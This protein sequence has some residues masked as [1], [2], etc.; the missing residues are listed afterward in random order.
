MMRKWLSIFLV[1][2]LLLMLCITGCS[3]DSAVDG[4]SSSLPENDSSQSTDT[5]ADKS[6]QGID[7]SEQITFTYLYPLGSGFQVVDSMNDN[8]I[9]K[10]VCELKNVEIE[11]IHPPQGQENEQFN[12]IIASGE[13]PDVITHGWGIPQKFP[14]GAS[15]AIDDNVYIPLN[16]L[17]DN[18]AP[19]FL[20]IIESYENVRKDFTTDN[21][22]IWGMGMVD[23]TVQPQWTGPTIRKDMFDKLN[24]EVPETI[25]EWYSALKSFVDNKAQFPDMEAPLILDAN[26]MGGF[27]TFIG[28]YDVTNDFI[29]YNGAVKYGP[30]EE[31]FKQYLLEMN[32]WYNEGLI[33][34]DFAAGLD[35]GAYI[36]TDKCAALATGGFWEYDG[37]KITSGDEN[38]KV[39]GAPF[40][41]TIKGEKVQISYMARR[42]HLGYHTAI[43]TT[44]ENPDRVV[45]FLDWFYSDEGSLLAN[46]GVENEDWKWENDNQ[47]VYTDK[48]AKNEEGVAIPIIYFKYLYSHG[49]F[50]R[51][52][53][54]ECP[55]YGIE[56]N[57]CMWTWLDSSE[58]NYMIPTFTS[59][60]TDEADTYTGIMGDISTYVNEMMIKYITGADSFDSYDNFINTIN[61]M[62]I[63]T[64]IKIKQA[65]LDR[66]NNR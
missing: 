60:T 66:F 49:A 21:G 9:I 61:K 31:G 59:L 20:K 52:W 11:F 24:L 34:P 17:I 27:H 43:T 53:D 15:K 33:H 64:A 40:P 58:S 41:S 55:S 37:W 13:L 51:E 44:C 28:A 16:D 42:S 29:Q 47:K 39:I 3:N 25:S 65:G 1:V 45:D 19:N 54:R 48:I 57:E 18:Y 30:L 35:R 14:G 5:N 36:T 62:N 22:D 7:R 2:T 6:T 12:L 23:K 10:E 56:A 63:D 38:F 50:L 46:W 26:G 4:E 32:K 8:R